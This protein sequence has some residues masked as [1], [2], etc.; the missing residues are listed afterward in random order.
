M[1]YNAELDNT[2]TIEAGGTLETDGLYTAVYTNGDE[3]IEGYFTASS[4]ALGGYIVQITDSA[5]ETHTYRAYT[6]EESSGETGETETTVRYVAEAK[7]NTYAEYY[8]LGEQNIY[9]APLFVFDEVTA[10]RATLYG[11]TANENTK[12]SPKAHTLT[13]KIRSSI[14]MSWTAIRSIPTFRILPSPI[15]P[16]SERSCS[17]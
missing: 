6:V 11:R 8:Y 5:G 3:R 13:T 4:S 9:Y 17:A 10:G 1:L 16:I 14:C 12:R 15:C 7:L 2:F